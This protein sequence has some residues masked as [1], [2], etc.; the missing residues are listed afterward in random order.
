M[1]RASSTSIPRYLTVLSSW[2][3]QVAAGRLA[4]SLFACRSGSPWSGGANACQIAEGRARCSRSTRRPVG[5]TGVSSEL[6]RM[7]SLPLAR[8]RAIDGV[9]LGATSSTLMRTTSH[10]RS[11]LSMARLNS[12]RSFC[13]LSPGAWSGWTR[14]AWATA[15]ASRR[16]SCHCSRAGVLGGLRTDLVG[17][18]WSFSSVAEDRQHGPRC[19]TRPIWRQLWE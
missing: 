5:R 9:A 6:Y 17:P 2:Y 11:L 8:R 4:S 19:A 3:G 14:R 7:A 15:V 1:A 12:A 13:G 18:A 10:P 16:S